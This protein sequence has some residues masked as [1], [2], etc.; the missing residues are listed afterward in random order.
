MDD[1]ITTAMQNQS[2]VDQLRTMLDSLMAAAK[3]GTN[4]NGEVEEFPALA[5]FAEF[6]IVSGQEFRDQ[7]VLP[8]NV[9]SGII[10]NESFA[11]FKSNYSA[12]SYDIET[13]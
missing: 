7:W 11:V 1:L 10:S 3:N 2:Y 12:I 9:A 6:L 5:A 8:S 4:S 13:K